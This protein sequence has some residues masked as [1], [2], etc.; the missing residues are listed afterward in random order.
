MAKRRED[1]E[2]QDTGGIAVDIEE[3]RRIGALDEQSASENERG[4]RAVAAK[5]DGKRVPWNLQD[6]QKYNLCLEAYGSAQKVQIV[7]MAP[8]QAYIDTLPMTV[9]P[10]Y[11]TLMRMFRHKYWNGE[12]MTIAWTVLDKG[13]TRA[14]GTER[15]VE[16]ES[17]KRAFRERNEDPVA[18]PQ[19]PP[20]GPPQYPGPQGPPQ[21]AGPPQGYAP[22]MNQ[23][24][25][26]WER[27]WWADYG[28]PPQEREPAPSQ[29]QPAPV[30]QIHQ[31]PPQPPAE[32]P[33]VTALSSQVTWLQNELARQ[34]ASSQRVLMEVRKREQ[35]ARQQ[36]MQPS[37]PINGHPQHA[38]PPTVEMPT[39]P[40]VAAMPVQTA[41]QEPNVPPEIRALLDRLAGIEERLSQS[42]Q[43]PQ[44]ERR[45]PPV[46]PVAMP[47]VRPTAQGYA[48]RAPDGTPMWMGID[49]VPVPLYPPPGHAP[50]WAQQ[51]PPWA[52]QP[53]QQPQPQ[54]AP[55]QPSPSPAVE[56]QQRDPLGFVREAF[57]VVK[58]MRGM[59]E[60][61]QTLAPGAI[62]SEVAAPVAAAARFAA[63]Q[64]ETPPTPAQ[65][66]EGKSDLAQIGPKRFDY[67][68]T[69]GWRQP[70][71]PVTG[72]PLNWFTT[73]MANL[74][75]L[76]DVFK[77]VTETTGKLQQAPTEER[78]SALHHEMGQVRNA[79]MQMQQVVGRAAQQPSLP[80]FQPQPQPQQPQHAPA[81]SQ[82]AHPHSQPAQPPP[83]AEQRAQEPSP[84]PP[85][86]QQRSP[87][88]PS[89]A[90]SGAISRL[91]PSPALSP[92][93]RGSWANLLD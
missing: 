20:Q 86:A 84:Q 19:G 69:D 30:Q 67:L 66:A 33:R 57:G 24:P 22:Q 88:S 72:E 42:I 62:P 45:D 28:P 63:S 15:L 53:Q 93:K 17:R 2:E 68:E 38:A 26:Y 73:L 25:P 71:N 49:N 60:S 7:Q 31:P 81:Q 74:D 23:P 65:A 77:V 12:D 44:P 41:P 36:S 61:F 80:P 3:A 83:P 76:T 64:V 54:Q 13:R 35:Q 46:A 75:H 27:P 79:I 85:A 34:E 5:R 91:E 51:P 8:Q 16:D 47:D 87:Q 6:W 37:A 92:R 82:P 18:P 90:M 78:V 70:I 1:D 11:D 32:D 59:L 56:Q 48:F 39:P 29:A 43:P 89:S 14:Q 52:Q 9:V 58:E 21:Y 55:P 4:D 50:P 40:S 10:Q